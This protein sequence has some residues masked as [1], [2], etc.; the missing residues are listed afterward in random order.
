MKFVSTCAAGLENLVVD[1]LNSYGAEI[2]SSRKGEIR[3]SAP[4]EAG[5]RT[6]LW[7]RFS[8][9]LVLELAEFVVDSTDDLYEAA[10]ST[11]W[12]EHLWV[13]D[14]FAV[15]CLLTAAGP[16]TNSMFGALRIKDGLV[17]RF[18]ERQGTRPTVE[19]QRPA[20][21]VYLQV[22]GTRP[23]VETQR[24]AVRVYL[25]VHGNRALLGLDL[26]GEGLHRRGYRVDSGPAPL[27]ENLAAA[28][29]ALSGWDG[30]TPLIDPM[31]GSATLLI[32]AA[33]MKA[34]SAPGLGRT[35]YG[36]TGWRGHQRRVWDALVAEALDRKA[37]AGK[38]KWPPLTGYDGDR[39]AV[40]AARKNISRA[41]FE[42]RIQVEQQELHQLNNNFRQPGYLVCNPP[43]GERVSDSQ[44]V[45]HLYRHMGERFRDQFPG[46]QVTL[47][48]A[49]ADYADHF[50]LRFDKSVKIFNGNLACRLFSGSPLPAA[51]PT[52]IKDWQIGN[53]FDQGAATELGNRLKKNFRKFHPWACGQNLDWYRLY[54]RDLPQFNVTIDVT[55]THLYIREFPPPPG[56]DPRIA[57]E[58]FR[59][60]TRTVRALLAAG[61]DQVMVHHSRSAKKGFEKRGLRHKQTEMREGKAVF[62][63]GGESDP[64]SSLFPDQRFVRKFLAQACGRGKFLSIFDTSG[65]ATISVALEGAIKTAT[66]GVDAR[67]IERLVINFSR[68]GLH[69][70]NHHIASD[71]VMGWLKKKRRPFDLIYICFRKKRYQQTEAPALEVGSGHRTLI[72]RAI[73]NLAGGGRLVVS[74][75]LPNF[76]LDPEVMEAYRCRDMSKKLS[77]PDL[78][79]VARNFRCWEIF[80]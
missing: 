39:S 6:C 4:L 2:A 77:S 10:K 37:S 61:R 72:D 66:L 7:S 46:W 60:V 19:T 53:E 50:K 49:A 36:L 18:R 28:I 33:L 80:R 1:E 16:V 76:E 12:E 24:P 65:G 29:M 73:V 67:N 34:D 68:N 48:T 38:Q 69:P 64:E 47:L 8:S 14:S 45:K 71:E 17:D 31:C 54:D 59:E 11:T 22:Q 35:Y 30:N 3:W 51:V 79:R 75:L 40:R 32:E 74:S 13:D 78:T 63:I 26:S 43:Y 27:K 55:T 70:D 15:D 56:K 21:R 42:D 62:V 58:R 57:A 41:G 44:S 23:T 5:Y 9:R 20:V 25:Q 52:T